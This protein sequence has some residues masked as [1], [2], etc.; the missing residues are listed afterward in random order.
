MPDNRIPFGEGVPNRGTSE[1][2][3]DD[4]NQQF[5]QS[6]IYQNFMRRNGLPTD[7]RVRLSRQQQSALENALRA[8]GIQIP[9][10]M[11]IDQGGNLNQKNTLVRNSLITAG[12]V[13][14]GLAGLGAAG[15]GPFSGLAGGGAG[16]AGSGASGL[17]P[18][19]G[20]S[21]WAV[22]PYAA[23]ATSVPT[24][25]AAVGGSIGAGAAGGSIP[26]YVPG[27]E[28]NSNLLFGGSGSAGGAGAAGAGAATAGLPADYRPNWEGNSDIVGAGIEGA[29]RYAGLTVDDWR[30]LAAG[31]GAAIPFATGGRA[32]YSPNATSNDPNIRRLMESMQGRLDKS[33]PLYDA[34]LAMSEGLLPTRY[35]RGGGQ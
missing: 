16:A 6:S 30:K 28:G 34:V 29:R 14:G 23:S 32:D 20:G 10:G 26:G 8:A 2:W 35:Q 27:F 15:I 12:A 17:A 11:H 13:G 33:E 21:P 7:G 9:G 5:R 24:G 1:R 22:T 19:A 25:A 18:I 3:L 4:W 31:I